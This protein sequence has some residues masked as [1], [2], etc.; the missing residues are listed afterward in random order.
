VKEKIE[1]LGLDRGTEAHKMNI[2]RSERSGTVVEPMLSTQWFV[3]AK[4][5]AAPA[6]AAVENGFTKF[7]PTQ[8]ENTYYAWLRDIRDWCISRQLW[9]G[10]QVPAWYDDEENVYVG[11]S[12]ADVRTKHALGDDIKLRQDPDILDTWFSSALWPFSTMGWPDKTPELA[13]WYPTATLTTGF[14]IIFFWVARMMMMGQYLM[15]SVPFKDVYIHAL[16]RDKNGDKMSKTKGNVVNPLEMIDKYG[17]DA[18]RFTLTAF[19]AQGRDMRWDENRAEGY[20]KFVNKIWQA[21]RFTMSHIGDVEP[22]ELQKFPAAE[23]DSM[24]NRWIRHKLRE[25][26][27]Q[28]GTSIKEYR[29]N[30]AANSIYH[31]IWDELCDWYL[32]LVKPALYGKAEHGEATKLG[33]QQTLYL[34]FHSLARALHPVMPFFTEELWAQLPATE[35][36]IMNATMP[37]PEDFASEHEAA[38]EIDFLQSTIVAVRRVRAEFGVPVKENVEVLVRT[39]ASSWETMAS[40]SVALSNLAKATMKALDG[41]SV[42]EKSATEVVTDTEL[43][44]PLE[45]LIDFAAEKVRLEKDLKKLDK[46]INGLRKQL[47]NQKFLNRAPN[48]I[49]ADK[50]SQLSDAEGRETRVKAA[51]ERLS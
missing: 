23:T 9:W 24:Y 46:E 13:R 19:A 20:S 2:G 44:L 39:D 42:P 6:L 22:S 17:C 27:L 43:F 4:P 34:V 33:V 26:I 49:V 50:K 28:Y 45:G 1:S 35:G 40:H 15:G 38:K 32:E 5:L 11:H 48:E 21:F 47:G 29:F 14:D 51:I 10:H 3:K 7:V 31:F 8:W 41:G 36:Y 30:E 16:I 12:E 37:K 25:A 18:F